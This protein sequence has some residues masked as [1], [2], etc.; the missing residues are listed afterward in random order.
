[1]TAHAASLD[2]RSSIDFLA[3]LRR[4]LPFPIRKVQTDR[5]QEF[6]FGFVLAVRQAGIRHRYIKP[7][8]PQQNGRSSAAI[9]SITRSSGVATTSI[10]S[11]TRPP[12]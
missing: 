9:A 3:E 5:E 10:A 6:S 12:H 4:V 1:M 7:R 2:T 8:R 11:P